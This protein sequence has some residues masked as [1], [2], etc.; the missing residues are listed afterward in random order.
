MPNIRKMFNYENKIYLFLLPSLVGLA[1]FYVVPFGISV[2]FAVIDNPLSRQFVGLVNL[3]DTWNNAAFSLAARNTVIFMGTAI[4]LNILLALTFALMLKPLNSA[5]KRALTVFFL[6][7][8]VIPSAS[9]TFF[10]DRMLAT[11][12]MINRLF[13]SYYNPPINWL[14]SDFAM[15]FVVFIFI[16]KNVGFN[17]ILFQAGLDFISKEY[18]E[19]AAIEGAGKIRQFFIVTCT[20]LTPTFILVF[21]LTVVNSFKV[22]RDIFLLTGSHP[23]FSIYLLQHFINNQM[24]HLNYPRMA[25]A[26]FFIFSFIFVMVLG[27]YKLQQRQTYW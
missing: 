9:L 16:W 8:L 13:A 6:L 20:Y 27:L 22:F 23:N 21:I 26:S 4:P 12:G 11:N 7:P 17:I 1:V 25:S 24:D 18:Y 2:Y 5:I 10:W 3:V 15:V 14:N 19:F